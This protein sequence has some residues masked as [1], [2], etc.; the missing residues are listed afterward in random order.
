V[1][2]QA[3]VGGLVIDGTGR[4]PIC[5]G[6]VL[7]ED[8]KIGCV[9]AADAIQVPD[10]A[11]VID[12]AGNTVMPGLI[13]CHMHVGFQ[14]AAQKCLYDSLRRG[15]TTVAGVTSGPAGVMLRDAIEHGQ[16]AGCSRYFV[17]AVVGCTNGHLKRTDDNIA[18]VTADGP[19]EVRKGVR[20]M[21]EA[22]ADFI[23]TAA[24]G[25]FQWAA[26]AMTWRNYTMA[27]L[28]ALVDEAHAWGRR[29]AVH[30]HVQPGISNSIQVGCDAIHHGSYIDDEGLEGI[31]EK[32]LFFVPTL[33]ITSEAVFTRESLP[34][35]MRERMKAAHD[36]H[37]EGVRK[38]HA[39]GLKI[40]V[41]TDGGP[42]DAAHEL[43]ELVDCGLSP[44]DA[45]VAGTRGSADALGILERV[46]TLEPGKLAD[47]VIV[48]GSPLDDISLPYQAQNIL[49]V[50]KD[51]RIEVSQEAE[52]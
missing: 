45:I 48:D 43:M 46:G 16:V 18:G 15:V 44:M 47:L 50:M 10:D 39:M 25:G 19:W 38:A 52:G 2:K 3:I 5:P 37:R 12:A 24:S 33:H 41:G 9:G 49:M 27:E 29:V 28:S 26:E 6:T 31:L 40:G 20:Q 11:K 51:G 35:H 36:P 34:E 22:G 42:G 13:D 4:D 7:V 23:K 30:A 8:D 32:D 14:F 1:N 17:G 21:V